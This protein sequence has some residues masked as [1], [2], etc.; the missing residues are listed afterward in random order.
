MMKT[1][2]RRR[3]RVV[4]RLFNDGCCGCVAL[5]GILV[6]VCLSVCRPICPCVIKSRRHF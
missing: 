2:K 3:E 1:M 6:M 5:V 4:R